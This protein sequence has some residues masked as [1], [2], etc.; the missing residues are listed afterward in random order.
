MKRILALF[1][2]FVFQLG[3]TLTDPDVMELLQALQ[4]QN[5]KLLEE[6]TSMKGQLTALDGKYQVILAGLAD[7]KKE[8]EALKSQMDGL[9]T[10]IASQ[11]VKLNQLI[12]QL[13]VQGADLEKLSAEIVK[14]KVSIEE[15][16]A[17]MEE[18]LAGKSPIPTNGLVAWYPFNGNANDESG[19]ENNGTVFGSSLVTDRFNQPN[20]AMG[21]DG[22]NDYVALGTYVNFTNFSI[23]M[24]IK[25]GTQN[26]HAVIIDNNHSSNNNWVCQT[27]ENWQTNGYY[28][29]NSANSF[30]LT[31]ENWSHIVLSIVG[32]STSVYRNGVL[33]SQSTWNLNYNNSVS[34]NLGVWK[35]ANARFWKGVQDDIGIWNRVLTAE[36]ISKIYKGEKF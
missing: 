12:A 14:L 23:S 32:G 30:T 35:I 10:Q 1:F 15:L 8:L 2:V 3:C 6:I 28:F 21:F 20:K 33:V 22:V 31:A 18:L 5:D 13:E 17:L 27:I 7:N 4:A 26:G 16:K 19:K 24:W 11:L 25:P 29:P 9:K 34:L 36:E